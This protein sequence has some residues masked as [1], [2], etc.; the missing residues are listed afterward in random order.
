MYTLTPKYP[1]TV[2][3]DASGITPCQF[4][5][6]TEPEIKALMLWEGNRQTH[7][8]QLFTLNLD[9]QTSETIRLVGDLTKVKKIGANMTQGHLLIEGNA[10]MRLGEEMRGGKITV[11]GN[12][13]SWAGLNMK[14][15]LIEIQGN[16]CDYVGAAYRGSNEG[17]AGGQ[18]IVHGNAGKEVGCYMLNGLITIHGNIDT[19]VG[20]HMKDG[21][22]H[23]RGDSVG[24]VGGEMR[25]GK[26]VIE[27][28]VPNVLPTFH[29]TGI[30]Q[31]VRVG[32]KQV[33]GPFYLFTG[34]LTEKGSGRI[35]L[36]QAS[37][38]HL[39]MYEKYLI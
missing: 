37:N 30:R 7:L 29:I 17:M 33:S 28:H 12:A 21:T 5:G 36:S 16:A 34:D 8:G 2:P 23:V 15:G 1:F 25:G 27:G 32:D 19:F 20:I 11:I 31:R 13:D 26:I 6:K 14:G 38:P 10:G 9:T 4:H 24:R 35:Y 3:I 39:N 22:I 18:I